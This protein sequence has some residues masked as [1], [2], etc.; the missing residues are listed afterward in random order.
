MEEELIRIIEF[1]NFDIRLVK[2]SVE[3]CKDIIM[4]WAYNKEGKYIDDAV[5]LSV[6]MEKYSI[7]SEFQTSKPEN[8]VCSIGFSTKEQKWYGWSHRAIFGFSIGSTCKKGDCHYTPDN[9]EDYRYGSVWG[10]CSDLVEDYGI[11]DGT[12]RLLCRDT[13]IE[14]NEDNCPC[15]KRGR[16]EWIANTLEDCKQMAIDFATSVS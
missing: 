12:S 9:F 3:G 13:R 2:C 4:V 15:Y 10:A 11:D 6:K 8:K 7:D 5:E 14:C 1:D 16:G